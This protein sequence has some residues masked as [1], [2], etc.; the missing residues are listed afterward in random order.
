MG[1]VNRHDAVGIPLAKDNSRFN[2]GMQ[3]VQRQQERDDAMRKA[4]MQPLKYNTGGT[5][6]GIGVGDQKKKAKPGVG[7]EPVFGVDPVLPQQPSMPSWQ[8]TNEAIMSN[9]QAGMYDS[10][11]TRALSDIVNRQNRL[12]TSRDLNS[13][14]KEDAFNRFEMDKQKMETAVGSFLAGPAQRAAQQNPLPSFSQYYS[15]PSK[16]DAAYA[17]QAEELGDNPDPNAVIEAMKSKFSAWENVQ[18][19]VP[20]RRYGGPVYP[21]QTVT[22]GEEGPEMMRVGYDGVAEVTPNPA[23]RARMQGNMPSKRMNAL[24][25]FRAKPEVY[26]DYL[27]RADLEADKL[28]VALSAQQRMQRAKELWDMEDAFLNGEEA[29]VKPRRMGGIVRPGEEYLM[30]EDGPENVT[31]GQGGVGY[32]TPNDQ[33][34]FANQQQ[35]TPMNPERQVG[36]YGG[37]TTFGV[38][39][40]LMAGPSQ[41]AQPIPQ[42]AAPVQQP[43]SAPKRS[44]RKQPIYFNPGSN[45]V[46][47]TGRSPIYNNAG[48]FVGDPSLYDQQGAQYIRQQAG[49][50]SPQPGLRKWTSKDGKYSA[51]GEMIGFRATQGGDPLTSEMVRIRKKDGVEVDVPLYRLSEEDR[52]MVM[53]SPQYDYQTRNQR[54]GGANQQSFNPNSMEYSPTG[55]NYQQMFDPNNPEYA[56]MRAPSQQQEQNSGRFTGQYGMG[57]VDYGTNSTTGNRVTASVRPGGTMLQYDDPVKVHPKATNKSIDEAMTRAGRARRQQAS[58]EFDRQFPNVMGSPVDISGLANATSSSDG[59]TAQ[60]KSMPE[61]TAFEPSTAIAIKAAEVIKNPAST[62]TDI[63]SAVTTLSVAGAT[64]EYMAKLEKERESTKSPS[65]MSAS[66]NSGASQLPPGLRSVPGFENP[67]VVDYGQKPV[68]APMQP[69]Q[70]AQQQ[71]AQQQPITKGDVSPQAKAWQNWWR[72]QPR[73]YQATDEA[74]YKEMGTIKLDLT[75]ADGKQM[76]KGAEILQISNRIPELGYERVITIRKPDGSLASVYSNYFSVEDIAKFDE[77]AE[78]KPSDKASGTKNKPKSAKQKMNDIIKNPKYTES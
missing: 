67:I 74:G 44:P 64:S 15:D 14:Q 27:S 58:E 37:S 71:P 23:T 8:E 26:K 66:V 47:N 51:E 4:Q 77:M 59:R 62:Q 49:D 29:P 18:R 73:A 39:T 3:M 78:R 40:A 50:S 1:I 42:V 20:E 52:Q 30:A 54:I 69:Q 53:S 56:A 70:P 68:P 63:D 21:G 25:T 32:V 11:T 10:Q 36:D 48:N 46:T 13:A 76:L 31:M 60:N 16:F 22:V 7:A 17:R 75:S 41:P 38:P 33:L 61:K 55:S 72:T 6:G 57:G 65:K 28:G 35:G 34:A 45:S 24:Q 19:Q 5:Y 2:A 12:M 43:P 9:I